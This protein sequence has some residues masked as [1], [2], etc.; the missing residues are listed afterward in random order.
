MKLTAKH[1]ELYEKIS[2]RGEGRGSSDLLV[3]EKK[4]LTFDQWKELC[5]AYHDWNGDPEGFLERSHYV[6]PDFC[7]LSYLRFLILDEVKSH[8]PKRYHVTIRYTGCYTVVVEGERSQARDAALERF[9]RSLGPVL[10]TPQI[11]T[12]DIKKED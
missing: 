10:A 12:I 6:L 5:K 2:K 9:K 8:L 11:E 1:L 3:E 4:L 7:I